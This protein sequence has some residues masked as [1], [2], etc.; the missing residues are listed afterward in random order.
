MKIYR[1]KD[2]IYIDIRN[3]LPTDISR[4]KFL[5]YLKAVSM[6]MKTAD[7]TGTIIFKCECNPFP[8]NGIIKPSYLES[9]LK[10]C[11]RMNVTP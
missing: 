11:Q 10:W 5:L 8:E 4:K 6:F 9:Y 2:E 1:S 3:C 7:N